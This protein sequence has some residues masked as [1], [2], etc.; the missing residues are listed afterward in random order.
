[1]PSL[2]EIPNDAPEFAFSGSMRAQVEPNHDVVVLV[3]GAELPAGDLNLSVNK[4][5]LKLKT[6]PLPPDIQARL[7]ATLSAGLR[8]QGDVASAGPWV[9]KLISFLSADHA[10]LLVPRPRIEVAR[11]IGGDIIGFYE[12]DVLIQF[13]V[14]VAVVASGAVDFHLPARF[15]YLSNK[16]LDTYL[17]PD[18]ADL[19][20]FCAYLLR[21]NKIGWRGARIR[22]TRNCHAEQ[23]T[24]LAT[25]A[26]RG[27]VITLAYASA[28]ITLG[29]FVPALLPALGYGAWAALGIGVVTSAFAW[30]K[31]RKATRRLHLELAEHTSWRLVN[32]TRDQISPVTRELSGDDAQQFLAELDPE[33]VLKG[34]LDL[35]NAGVFDDNRDAEAVLNIAAREAAAMVPVVASPQPPKGKSNKGFLIN[36][37]FDEDF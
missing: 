1:V 36:P 2:T 11:S 33:E 9:Q 27:G 28:A 29:I 22:A 19:A 15:P 30:K 12:G 35:L 18:T 14:A 6:G 8:L 24:L 5:G 13:V 3:L 21:K 4:N 10:H 34:S 25:A 23:T 31:A 26:T 16:A 20:D 37:D 17:L 7:D 32:F